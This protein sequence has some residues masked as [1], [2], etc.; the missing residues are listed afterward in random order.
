MVVLEKQEAAGEVSHR[1]CA[2]Q[3]HG[4][5]GTLNWSRTTAIVRAVRDAHD[6]ERQAVLAQHHIGQ[7]LQRCRVVIDR[8]D[9]VDDLPRQGG[10]IAAFLYAREP[11][12][13]GVLWFGRI[14]MKRHEAVVEEAGETE[15]LPGESRLRDAFPPLSAQ[16]TR[17]SSGSR[18]L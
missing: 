8:G 11:G 10:E 9:G 16:C 15:G 6:T 17:R 7:A 12:L 4:V 14:G 2:K 18:V 13:D 5:R 1:A 3:H